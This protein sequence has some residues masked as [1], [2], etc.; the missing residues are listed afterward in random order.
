H[1]EVLLAHA[2]LAEERR[3]GAE[4]EALYRFSAFCLH[5]LK[6]LTA[7]LSL[8]AQN[9]SRHGDDPE[10]RAS[11]MRTVTHTAEQMTSLLARFSLRAREDRE[12]EVLDVRELVVETLAS[13][14]PTLL[15]GLEEPERE[16]P[17]V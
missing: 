9:A 4:L 11:A 14:D 5:D 2:R 1:V 8:V 10:F 3:A 6:N 17:R 12:P 7:R 13:I 16:L 15:R